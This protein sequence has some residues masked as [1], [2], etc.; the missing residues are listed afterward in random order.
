MMRR[1][2]I[3]GSGGHGQVVADILARAN[4]AGTPMHVLGFLDDNPRVQG[5]TRLGLPILGTSAALDTIDHDAVLLAIGDNERR[6]RLFEQLRA[7]GEQF[8]IAR[9][10]TAIIAPDVRIGPGTM[11]CAGVIINTGSTI[12]MNVILNTGCTVDH[13]NHIGDHAHIAPGSH[14]GGDV[15]VRA[16]AMVGIGATVMPQRT[17]GSWAVVG[18]GALVNRDLRAHVVAVGVPARV[19]RMQQEEDYAYSDGVARH[20]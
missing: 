3:I 6:Q 14:L 10:P 4:V 9:H 7:R 12:G 8:V 15:E 17:V 5:E 1:V 16:G 19:I 20:V 18:A 11:I 13:H 2:L